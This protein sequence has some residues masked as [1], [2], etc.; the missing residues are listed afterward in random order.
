[1]SFPVSVVSVSSVPPASRNGNWKVILSSAIGEARN[2][3]VRLRTPPRET[4]MSDQRLKRESFSIEESMVSNIWEIATIV[5]VLA[6]PEVCAGQ[7]RVRETR[8]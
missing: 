6:V 7:C 4:D 8:N 1:M 3:H 2:L 5:E